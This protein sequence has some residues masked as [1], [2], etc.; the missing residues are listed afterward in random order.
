VSQFAGRFEAGLHQLSTW[1]KE[2]RLHYRED[3]V[4]G[5]ENAPQAF[6]RMLEGKNVG[7]QLVKVSD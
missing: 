5:L 1:L 6:I 3:I 7:K 2:G 4:N